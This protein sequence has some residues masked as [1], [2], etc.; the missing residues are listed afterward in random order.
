MRVWSNDNG[1]WAPGDAGH[2]LR[3]YDLCKADEAA[4]RDLA[5]TLGLHPL[6]IDDCL[7]PYLHTPKLEDFG[8]YLFIILAD[9]VSIEDTTPTVQELD[10]FLG[11]DF[12]VTYHDR[13]E[14]PAAIAAVARA[15]EQGLNTRPGASGLFYEVADR[16]VDAMIPI[17]TELGEE[18]DAIEDRILV[19]GRLGEDHRRVMSRRALAGK[20]RRLLTPELQFMIRL[21][22]GEFAAIEPGDR[23]YFRDV[24]DHLL[25]VDLALEEL[26][27]DTEVALSMYL[28]ALNNKLNEVMKVL[29]VVS[30]LALPGTLITGVFGTNFDN[31]PGLHSQEG[32]ALMI[33]SIVG[34]AIGMAYFFR[35]RHW[36]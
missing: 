10:V 27:E 12:L 7:S 25:R 16:T 28:S 33:A 24:Y 1:R 6:A 5:T 18:L 19:A 9:L 8:A 17:V 15:I 31:V 34:V 36:F 26:R 29:A 35:K 4:L 14:E 22:R 23:P 21:G 20:V 13:A 3:W 11:K 2:G 30:A 32:F